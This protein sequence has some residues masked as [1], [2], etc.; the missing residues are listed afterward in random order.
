MRGMVPPVRC[1]EEIRDYIM[2]IRTEP[3]EVC[4]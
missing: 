4:I 1:G 3:L 2:K